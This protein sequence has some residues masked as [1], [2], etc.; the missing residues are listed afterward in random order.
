M[1]VLL[2]LLMLM[3]PVQVFAGGKPYISLGTGISIFSDLEEEGVEY[4]LDSGFRINTA[5]GV[6]FDR[7][8]AE[9]EYSY[10]DVDLSSVELAGVSLDA[11]G[12]VDVNSLMANGYYKF[13]DIGFLSPYIGVGV[14]MAW[15]EAQLDKILDVDL[16]LESEE[17][18]FAYQL[19]VGTS[20]K[21]SEY[22][23]SDIG[24]RYF[25]A[26]ET[27]AHELGVNLR[28]SF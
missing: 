20:T 9:I 24:Y 16:S 17:S 3:V 21:F 28:Y 2:I 1:R 14:G 7:F 26:Q 10:R 27:D 5:L 18:G 13:S 8:R 11:E 22:L 6:E 4:N 25:E 12:G 15:E 19:M 23:S